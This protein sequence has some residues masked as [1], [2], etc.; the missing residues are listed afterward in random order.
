[1]LY[2]KGFL[3]IRIFI[4]HIDLM[5]IFFLDSTRSLP[6]IFIACY[7][8]T[9]TLSVFAAISYSTIGGPISVILHLIEN[10]GF[11]IKISLLC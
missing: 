2:I 5:H 6:E 3:K 4:F 8:S 10:I 9:G 11:L 7:H 1:M